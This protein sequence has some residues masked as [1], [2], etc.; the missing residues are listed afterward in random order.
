MRLKTCNPKK[1]NTKVRLLEYE[2][3]NF[4]S[5]TSIMTELSRLQD[6]FLSFANVPVPIVNSSLLLSSKDVVVVTID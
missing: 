5:G 6:L 4:V 1:Q 2:S 3:T